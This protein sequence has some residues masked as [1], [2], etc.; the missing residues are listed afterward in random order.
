[1]SLKK[2]KAKVIYLKNYLREVKVHK[3]LGKHH[4]I[5]KMKAYSI[6]A[7]EKGKKVLSIA[8]EFAKF[9][10]LSKVRAIFIISIV[11]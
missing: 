10:D 11:C 5:V 8:L 7:N 1:M 4:S 2:H 6:D 3:I 9:G